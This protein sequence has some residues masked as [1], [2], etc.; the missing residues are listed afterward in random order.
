[1]TNDVLDIVARGVPIRFSV[2]N[3]RLRVWAERFEEIEP[4]LLDLIDALPEGT[5]LYDVGA[6]VGLFSLYAAL[7]RR[8]RIFAFEAEAQN[9][10]TLEL[11]HYLN[12]D[13]LAEPLTTFN[14]AIADAIGIG[15]IHTRVYGAGEHGKVLDR[16]VA[17]DT[18]EGFDV[19]HVQTVLK[20]PLDR[21]VAECDLPPPQMLKIDGALHTVFIELSE[22]SGGVEVAA[23]ERHGLR[24]TSKVPVVRLRGGVYPGLF[25]CVFRRCAK[26]IS[27]SSG[28]RAPCRAAGRNDAYR[29]R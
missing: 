9:Y 8:C 29:S 4:E 18:R 1:M 22:L 5:V 13:R 16:A 2:A 10:A 14:V 11:N 12:R 15:R 24:L 19:A 28:V 26:G 17:Q 21:L 27:A 23:L 3:G 6:S 7:Q 20:M 25:N